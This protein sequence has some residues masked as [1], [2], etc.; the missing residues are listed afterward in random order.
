MLL[1]EL[2]I[3]NFGIYKGEHSIDL[4]PRTG[5]PIILFG[6]LN[7]GGKTTLLDALQLVL[8]GRH[9]KTSNRGRMAYEDYL[10]E[11]INR[12][13]LK[14]EAMLELYF[15][16]HHE[17]QR[18]KYRVTREW[19][20]SGK[21]IREQLLVQVNGA[22]DQFLSEHWENK[23]NEFIPANISDL[24]FFDGEKIETLADARKSAGLIK[25]G[26]H[27]LLG[28][29]VVDNLT[30]DLV[31]LKNRRKIK[32]QTAAVQSEIK[33]L[34]ARKAKL[35]EE[36]GSLNEE[37]EQVVEELKQAQYEY[38]E[39]WTSYK[40]SGGSL[41]DSKKEF[42]KEE[43]LAEQELANHQDLMRKHAEGLAP[44]L[45][46]EDLLFR[47]KAQAS[48]EEAGILT[49]A[50][51]ASLSNRDTL[52]LNQLK[53]SGVSED[54]LSS[55]RQFTETDRQE[56][57]ASIPDEIYLN[58][59]SAAF[60][61]LDKE[62]F[63]Q[64]RKSGIA[65]KQE[66]EKIKEKQ[67]YIQD[68]LRAV[69]DDS[70]I[71][72]LQSRINVCKVAKTRAEAKLELLGEQIAERKLQDQQLDMAIT[73][74]LDESSEKGFDIE[75]QIRVLEQAENVNGVLTEF[76]TLLINENI[77]KLENMILDSFQ[78]L[79]RKTDLVTA[80]SIDPKSY[81]LAL[82]GK[83]A[84]PIQANRLSAGE[85]QLLAISILWGLAKA[86]GRPLP[87]IIDTPLGRLDSKHRNHLIENYF[88]NASHQV[89]LLSTDQEI[90]K[91]YCKGLEPYI[92]AKYHIEYRDDLQSS[93][94]SE[95]YF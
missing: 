55:V 63:E 53:A 88:P 18:A 27:A 48:K 19:K 29:D 31:A 92:A 38:S 79:V 1:D 13:A 36:L 73:K 33:S 64:T 22:E 76:R 77:Q 52:L 83:D 8:Y 84:Q 37:K 85:R 69:P 45:L 5:R 46:V 68:K 66:Y 93:V 44:I 51:V 59:P 72:D 41:Y 91:E 81:R 61:G 23:V 90:D 54:I 17:G 21:S 28:L 80:I 82:Y 56:R 6:G 7:G 9:A 49:R 89:I 39:S 34:E 35:A 40:I 71:A 60:Q 2:N 67:Q 15:W 11:T 86:S 95:G 47:A 25:T 70:V 75:R 87:A 58:I 10:R 16:Y 78:S 57:Q 74:K 42:E 32:Q 50:V 65:L 12:Y 62:T 3:Y 26:I 20:V 43:E 94:I 24:F 14:K 30:R 4:Q